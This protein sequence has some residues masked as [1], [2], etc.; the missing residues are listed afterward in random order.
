[1][2]EGCPTIRSTVQSAIPEADSPSA[3]SSASAVQRFNTPRRAGDTEGDAQLIDWIS[4]TYTSHTSR[5]R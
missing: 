2:V 1:P 3:I 4:R 5:Y